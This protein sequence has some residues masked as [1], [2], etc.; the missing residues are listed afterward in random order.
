MTKRSLK[1]K[2]L[3]LLSSLL[4]I[5]LF[6]V[7]WIKFHSGAPETYLIPKDYSGIITVVY[8]EDCGIETPV[9]N[10]RRIL[11]IPDSGILII[12]A[13]QEGGRI[14][15]EY[16]FVNQNKERV[17]VA[18]YE[19]HYD[20][21]VSI[22]GIKFRGSGVISGAMPDGSSSSESPFAIRY[23]DLVVYQSTLKENVDYNESFRQMEDLVGECRKQQQQQQY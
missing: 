16:Y 12:R 8:G 7:I 10:G 15:H 5:V 13:E 9:E 17:K 18:P 23:S 3:W 22:P 2:A 1:T 19:N 6:W 21:T 4:F 14:D 20:G 11:E